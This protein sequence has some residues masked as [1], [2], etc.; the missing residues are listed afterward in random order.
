MD[1]G[2]VSL[3]GSGISALG[4]LFGGR[5]AA[6][7]S[8]RTRQMQMDQFNAMMDR[9]IQRRVADAKKA[10]IHPLAALGS[11]P[12]AGPTI[13]GAGVGAE[14]RAIA[15]AGEA[16]GRGIS[17]YAAQKAQMENLRADTAL[18]QAEASY[19]ARQGPGNPGTDGSQLDSG[20]RTFPFEPAPDPRGEVI[21]E[22]RLPTP[23]V[24]N[25]GLQAGTVAM[26]AWSVHSDGHRFKNYGPG[27]ETDEMKQLVEARERAK[28]HAAWKAVENARPGDPKLRNAERYIFTHVD[29][30]MRR[31]VVARYEKMRRAYERNN[32]FQRIQ[33]R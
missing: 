19:W 7:E 2:T 18:K 26:T 15:D 30:R 20:V 24:D 8:R 31:Q 3:L 33:R 4:S 22:S 25:P 16:V 14:G 9:T 32:P 1:P 13:T 5:S 23:S 10:G 28:W 17:A 11:S 6:R 29:P 21:Y 27:T 12:G